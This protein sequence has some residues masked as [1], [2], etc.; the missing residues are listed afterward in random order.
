MQISALVYCK[1]PSEYRILGFKIRISRNEDPNFSTR[2]QIFIKKAF[3]LCGKVGHHLSCQ[4]F[5]WYDTVV[6]CILL[7][8]DYLVFY[9][10]FGHYGQKEG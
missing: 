9:I 4:L 5:A 8:K 1:F 3:E 2:M 10:F 6:Y 7:K